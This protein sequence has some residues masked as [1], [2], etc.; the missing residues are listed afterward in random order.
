MPSP[1]RRL[2]SFAKTTP[3]DY[4]QRALVGAP[5]R[6]DPDETRILWIRHLADHARMRGHGLHYGHAC[7]RDDFRRSDRDCRGD[8][9]CDRGRRPRAIH[10]VEGLTF[11]LAVQAA[12]RFWPNAAL[13]RQI[14]SGARVALGKQ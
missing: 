9:W 6:D 5:E 12:A 4:R 11:R 10:R 8:Y 1:S 13:R 3:F 2:V 7:W 14:D